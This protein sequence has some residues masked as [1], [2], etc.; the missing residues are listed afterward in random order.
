M[1][2]LLFLLTEV[3]WQKYNGHCYHCGTKAGPWFA[4]EVSMNMYNI[5]SVSQNS[6]VI[7]EVYLKSESLSGTLEHFDDKCFN[8]DRQ[9]NTI[10]SIFKKNLHKCKIS[11]RVNYT[12]ISQIKKK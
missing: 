12:T 9:N 7:F 11:L 3:T 2:Y 5:S 4:A 6:S 8:L 10:S 1:Y